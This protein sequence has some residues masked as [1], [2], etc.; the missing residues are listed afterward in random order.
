VVLFAAASEEC[1]K[2]FPCVGYWQ[3]VRELKVY[4]QSLK[5]GEHTLAHVGT[6][7]DS[8]FVL[9]PRGVDPSSEVEQTRFL[10]LRR[11]RDN[12]CEELF[13]LLIL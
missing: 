11:V 7:A 8:A 9:G 10:E 3:S 13:E 2:F 1:L 6:A 4:L 5:K 12:L